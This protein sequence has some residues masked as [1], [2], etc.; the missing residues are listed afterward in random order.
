MKKHLLSFFLLAILWASS[1]SHEDIVQQQV[2]HAPKS[3]FIAS[4]EQ[5]DSRTYLEEGKYLRWTADD[6]L[7]IFMGSTLRRQFRFIGETGDNSGSFE[8]VSNLD[9]ATGANLETPCHYAVYPYESNPIISESGVLTVELPSQQTY[10]AN[11]FGL[12]DNTMVAVTSSLSDMNLAFKN[13]CGYLKFK[14]YGNDVTVKKIILQSNGGEKLSGDATLTAAYGKN[15][16]VSMSPYWSHDVI[17]L[18]CGETGVKIGST[19]NEATEFWFVLPE[20]SFSKGFT[21]TVID[22]NGGSYVK[23]T[24]KNIFVERNVIKPI[25]ALEVVIEDSH[26]PYVTFT[27]EAEQTFYISKKINTLEYSVDNGIWAELGT[28]R[29]TFGGSYGNLRLRGQNLE[30]TATSTT[31]YAKISFGN[32]ERVTCTGDIRTLLNYKDYTNVATDNARFCHLFEDCKV[33]KTA[34]AL[35]ATTLA[36]AC[37]A[38]MFKN[39]TQLSIAPELPATTLAEACYQQMFYSCSSL[40]TAPELPAMT[41]ASYCYDLMFY[42]CTSL[43]TAPELPAMTLA[44]YCYSQMFK[45]TNLTTAPELPAT[46]LATQCYACMFERTKLKVAPALPATTLAEDCYYGMFSR[47]QQLTE[48]PELPATTLADGCYFDMFN[49]CTSLVNAPKLPA[50]TLASQCYGYMFRECTSLVKA[51]ELPATTL[52]EYGCYK[53]MFSEC[54]NLITPPSLPATTLDRSCY[55]EMFSNCTSLTKSPELPATTLA[56]DCYKLMFNGCSSL[57]TIPELPATE[58][59]SGCYDSMFKYCKSLVTVSELP[60]TTLADYCYRSMFESCTG[61]SSSPSLPATTLASGCYA[62]MFKNCTSL[63]TSPILPATTLLNYCYESMFEGCSSLNYVT[64][65][66]TNV[67]SYHCLYNWLSGVAKRGTIVKAASM[68]SL[69]SSSVHGIPTNWKTQNYK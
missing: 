22:V 60:A 29:I 42:W 63:I 58:L 68:N 31:S 44:P 13:A 7:A 9:Y 11:S 43:T 39:C 66:A 18:D 51:P 2:T 50:T 16:S 37:Y 27:S 1:C 56:K 14:F 36:E 38:S 32:N 26:T 15:P 3:E 35:P 53:G 69:S 59:V 57:E 5:N 4:F 12:G 45:S 23:K 20:T 24:D 62:S 49:L 40:T 33:L 6:E 64:M 19:K 17:T 28:S 52:T 61:L 46:T 25:S 67:S 47:C 21:L 8:E 34:P 41:L 48:A 54:R 55:E 10:A 30:G 65:L